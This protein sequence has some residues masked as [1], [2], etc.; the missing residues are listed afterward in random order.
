Q[1]LDRMDRPQVDRIDGIPPAIA[2]DQ[3]NPVRTSRS[4]VGT[5]TE[6]NDHLKL[7]YARA[8]E[9]Y[10][11]NC[12]QPV[13][14]DTP[15]SIR[16]SL[17]EHAAAA[18]DPRLLVCFTV[19]IPDNFEEAEI[20][21]LLEAQGYVRFREPAGR[22]K[23]RS[24]TVIQD[25]FRLGDADPSRVVE[26]LEA[27]LRG[28]RGRAAVHAL[29]ESG[30]NDVAVWRY[31]TDLH[32]AHCDIS[33]ATPVPSHFSFNSPLGACETCKGFG[34]TIGIDMGLVIPDGHKT[35]GD[36]AIKP[37]QT[38]TGKEC[39]DDLVKFAKLRG[40]PMDVPWDEL[41][42]EQ[43][44][45]VTQGEGKARKKVWYG[46]KGY[47]DY[48][49]RN[50][51]KMHV[52]VLLS[53]Y[54]SY[55]LCPACNGARLKPE[56]LLWRVGPYN[57]HQLML[58]PIDTCRDFFAQLT[59]PSAVDEA[60]DLLLG[61]IRARLSYLCE[62]GLAYLTLDRQSRTLSGGE[63]QRINLTT[64]LGTSLVNTLFVL[65]EPSIGLH[66]R[67]MLRVI[68]VMKRLRDS[69]NSLV[70]VEHDPQIMLEA[71]RILDMGPGAG[72]HGGEI[73]FAGTPAAIRTDRNSLTGA[74]LA[75]RKRI[76]AGKRA[77]HGKAP[78]EWLQ[79][80]GASEHNLRDVDLRIPLQRLVC[81]TGVSGSGKSTLVEDVLY[82]AMLKAAG[83]PTE[84]PGAHRGL[85]GHEQI[86]Q[87]VMI[88][89]SP[90]GRTTRSNP[91][92]YVGAF[93]AVRALFAK[94]PDAI[95]RKYTAGTFSFNSGTGRCPT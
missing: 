49:E 40:F 55:T 10:C 60:S 82:P 50:A 41:S 1:F 84:A 71:D 87:T 39:Q 26:A 52:R 29:D 63:V 86:T 20:R 76:D 51:Y 67:D 4:T 14:R 74:Y 43:Q 3:T 64:A 16:D 6:L 57:L 31:S 5:M 95:E 61:E 83:K 33:Y 34:R 44:Q 65:D 38:P 28:G 15:A 90:I 59:L 66:P 9:L 77:A 23:P 68:R 35:L 45:W 2:I 69:G 37:W 89:Q 18:G 19:A 46:V 91:A 42:A 7:L 17:A 13:R 8:G 27:A 36:G 47:F 81:V 92:S 88:D 73:V 30:D 94:L 48:L 22:K 54:R 32:C 79:L 24:L 21:K 25:R 12:G 75:G 11:R 53:K 62:V 58:L 85:K 78:I 72:E 93:D 70:V 80:S 56:S